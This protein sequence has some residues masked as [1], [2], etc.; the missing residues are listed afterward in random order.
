MSVYYVLATLRAEGI[1]FRWILYQHFKKDYLLIL[2]IKKYTSQ[3]LGN[4]LKVTQVLHRWWSQDLNLSLYVS[5]VHELFTTLGLR[6]CLLTKGCLQLWSPIKDHTRADFSIY[7]G[8]GSSDSF[9]IQLFGIWT[10]SP[11][12]QC[13]NANVQHCIK[14]NSKSWWNPS[15]HMLWNHN[16]P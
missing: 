8:I 6:S 3:S 7:K 16:F 5:K 9:R 13:I 12:K 15:T 1:H 4:L 14:I 10:Y 2:Q 11:R